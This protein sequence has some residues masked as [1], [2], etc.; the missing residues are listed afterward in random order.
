MK[1]DGLNAAELRVVSAMLD[2]HTQNDA[3]SAARVGLRTLQRYLARDQVRKAIAE[4]A[5]RRLQGVT[6]VLSRHAERA[7]QVLGEMADGATPSTSSRVR[8]CVAVLERA[9]RAI[10]LEDHARRL[11]ELE[12]HAATMAAAGY[13]GLPGANH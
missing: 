5:L 7:A 11:D 12:K 2:H 6:V 4:G 1:R 10:E 9:Q 8:A 3:A 13:P